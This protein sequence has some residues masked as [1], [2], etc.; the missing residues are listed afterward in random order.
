VA[1]F[2]VA[3]H[4]LSSRVRKD[5]APTL[6]D[7]CRDIAGVQAQVMSAAEQQLWTRRQHS[8]RAEIQS[9]LWEKRTLVK[10]TCMRRTLHFLTAEDFQLYMTALKSSSMETM[11][12]HLARLGAGPKHAAAM[13]A[14]VM[15]ALAD[16]PRTQQEL[17]AS[18]KRAAAPSM[19]K[20]LRFAWSALRPAIIEA[21]IVYGP[22]RGNEV[23]FVRVDQW[24]PRARPIGEEEARRELARRFLS[25]FGPATVLDFMKW[26]G[27][28]AGEA[29]RAWTS[30]EDE[31]A[32]VSIDGASQS[33][34][35]RDLA[36]LAGHAPEGSLRLLPNFD[37][38]LLAHAKKDHLIDKRHYKRV[39]RNQGWITAVVLADGRVAGIWSVETRKQVAVVDVQMFAAVPRATRAFIEREAAALAVFLGATCDVRIRCV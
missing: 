11:Y 3:R 6:V 14:T 30:L 13:I 19:R 1:A 35:R 36:A 32:T 27:I 33:L 7:V 38:F 39:Y 34:L 2:R 21:L 28:R 25:A 29:R 4:H 24:L 22:P 10:T 37:P 26:S 31:L 16:G 20:W 8:T 9:S 23:T 18:S 17:I 12:G 5:P 15:D